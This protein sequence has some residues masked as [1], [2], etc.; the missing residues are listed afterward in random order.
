MQ[1]VLGTLLGIVIFALIH[2]VD[3]KGAWLIGVLVLLQ[4]AIEVV[5]ARHYALALTFITPTALTIAAAAG[6]SAP[7]IL[8]GERMMDTLLG[9]VVAL[10]VLWTSELM[11]H[12]NR[13]GQAR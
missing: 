4:F 1:R 7:G 13:P 8:I 12:R 6:T 11:A 10:T 5:V 9:A 3:P 2:Q